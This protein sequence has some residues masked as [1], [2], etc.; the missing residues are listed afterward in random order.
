MLKVP[1]LYVVPKMVKSRAKSHGA[2]PPVI[3]AFPLHIIIIDSFCASSQIWT[4]ISMVFTIHLLQILVPQKMFQ[5]FDLYQ[6]N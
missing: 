3:L 6:E 4:I 5:I 1:Y 2:P